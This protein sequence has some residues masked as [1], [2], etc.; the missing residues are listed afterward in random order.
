[1]SKKKLL[2]SDLHNKTSDQPTLS[3]SS[4]LQTES[5]YHALFE[6]LTQGV[7]FRDSTGKITAV[8]KAAEEILGVSE[9][10]LLGQLS[11]G[12]DRP[13]LKEDGT[14]LE[15]EDHPSMVALRT[16]T[17]VRNMILRVP[18][19]K[20][21]E[22]RWITA[23]AI[24]LFDANSKKITQVYVS[25]N[26]ITEFKHSKEL[27]DMRLRLQ[28]AISALSQ[29]A[30][31]KR[32]LTELFDN[33]T[34][35]L[36]RILNVEYTNIVQ[37]LPDKDEVIFRA[38]YGWEQNVQIDRTTAPMGNKSLAGYTLSSKRPVILKNLLKET[39]FNKPKLLLQHH[40]TSGMCVILH[41]NNGPY[42]ALCI[43]SRQR[44]NFTTDDISYLQ[45]IA[46]ILSFA[47][48]Q[49]ETE[50]ELIQN[51]HKFRHI[52][53][54]LP[55]II[56]IADA[57]GKIEFF[58]EQWYDYTKMSPDDASAESWSKAVH[59]QDRHRVWHLWNETIRTGQP[60]EVEYQLRNGETGKYFWFL[61]RAVPIKDKT[62]TILQWFGTSTNIH[63][64]KQAQQ[65][66]EKN[67]DLT[68]AILQS[69]PSHVI[70]LDNQGTILAVND[71]LKTFAFENT[72][73]YPSEVSIGNNY[74]K[75]LSQTRTKYG[76]AINKIK[77]G[78]RAVLTREVNNYSLE[79]SYQRGKD[80]SWFLLQVAPLKH[81]ESGVV[82][83]HTDITERKKLEKQ[84]DEFMS[85][86]SHEL[87]TPLTSIKAYGQVLLT[88]F[89]RKGDASSVQL[90]TKMDSQLNKLT[91]LISDFLDVSRIEAGRLH[92]EE[93]WFNLKALI[94]EVRESMQLTSDVHKLV[95]DC[96]VECNV[97]ANKDRLGQVVIN[98]LSN[99]IKYSPTA[100]K[101]EI[102]C[103]RV[104]EEV[105]VSVQDHGIGIAPEKH[106]K[107][108]ER[109][110]RVTDGNRP[111]MPGLGLGLYISSEIIKL[112]EGKIWVQGE[113]GKGSIFSFSLPKKRVQYILHE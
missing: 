69:L 49:N 73:L 42:G 50:H 52:A 35:Q 112:F 24:P 36:A 110:Y 46:N 78:I 96:Q 17:E 88:V 16:R 40:I 19:F 66:L 104:N 68:D 102:T 67:T 95:F 101:I 9:S 12:L 99:A 70:V 87:K 63:E 6:T 65:A 38:G 72:T 91:D 56:W 81:A 57:K 13:C 62:G 92:I 93:E 37:M 27:L 76:D 31:S 105:V 85:I 113:A 11:V 74:L 14:V 59:P 5:Q 54:A 7:V 22:Y 20:K 97:L 83:S 106:A 108:F 53:Q 80:E 77:Y 2:Q 18:N 103:K 26:D 41:K 33:A 98:F 111:S 8:N 47:I 21:N 10:Q 84:K 60:Y 28:Q 39:R 58:N 1:M 79:Y 64:Q 94:E 100:D 23:N 75:V 61:S 51:E 44:R 86:A 71:A 29:K 34:E 82:V 32:P 15:T 4:L 107:I 43:F 3:N 45:S 55:Q 109:F 25:F 90:L 30:L 89:K 48:Q